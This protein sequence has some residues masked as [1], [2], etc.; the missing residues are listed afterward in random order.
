MAEFKN[1]HLQ[2]TF[3]QEAP[4]QEQENGKLFREAHNS[5][6]VYIYTAY[7][8]IYIYMIQGQRKLTSIWCLPNKYVHHCKQN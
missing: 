1:V 8:R 6:I 4:Q 7:I 2:I 3:S 5:M